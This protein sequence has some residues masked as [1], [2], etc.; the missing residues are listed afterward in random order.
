MSYLR[1]AVSKVDP[2]KPRSAPVQETN[3]DDAVF[4]AAVAAAKQKLKIV[5]NDDPVSPDSEQAPDVSDKG[6]FGGR[7]VVMKQN[8][9]RLPKNPAGDESQPVGILTQSDL[10]N[11]I[12]LHKGDRLSFKY[13]TGST[14]ACCY[15]VSKGAAEFG[16]DI[17]WTDALIQELI[18]E[19]AA[20][21]M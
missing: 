9:W 8:I 14:G 19:G 21:L 11:Y 5:E 6:L 10:D 12:Y 7:R 3:P 13:K 20:E 18:D 17:E 16:S 2:S 15:V 4:A 1:D